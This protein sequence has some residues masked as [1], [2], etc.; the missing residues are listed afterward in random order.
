MSDHLSELDAPH[1]PLAF[2]DLETRF[3]RD[4]ACTILRT[5]EQ[6]EGI[7]EALVARMSPEERLANVLKTMKEN[8]RTQTRH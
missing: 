4:N 1:V 5:M 3:G 7:R 8:L 2:S 6:F